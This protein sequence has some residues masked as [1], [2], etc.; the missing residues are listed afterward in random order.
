MLFLGFNVFFTESAFYIRIKFLAHTVFDVVVDDEVEFF[1]AEAVVLGEDGVD[2]VDYWFGFF[3]GK[4]IILYFA[5][6]F[7]KV[8]FASLVV[9]DNLSPKA[10]LRRRTLYL[11]KRSCM[12]ILFPENP[13]DNLSWGKGSSLVFKAALYQLKPIFVVCSIPPEDSP[14]YRVLSSAIYGVSGYWVVPHPVSDGGLC[15]DE[16]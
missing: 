6:I 8:L 2:L 1:F 15:D 12:V 5:S 10:A 3:R 16:F 14:D 11:V 4:F 13:Y 7:I 9:P